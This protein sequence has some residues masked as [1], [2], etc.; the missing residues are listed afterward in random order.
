ME[1]AIERHGAGWGILLGFYRILR[2]HPFSG[3]GFDPVPE[4]LFHVKH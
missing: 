2:C 1:E 3:G 4:K